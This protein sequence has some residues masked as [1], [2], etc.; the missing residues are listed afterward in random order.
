MLAF[1]ARGGL[2]LLVALTGEGLTACPTTHACVPPAGGRCAGPEPLPAP[3]SPTR[4]GG[5]LTV[6]GV[7][8]TPDGRTLTVMVLCGGTL[9]LHEGAAVSVT[10]VAGAVG[11][12]AMSCALVPL[13]AQL[14]QPLGAR[15]LVDGVSG[16][17]L[18]PVVCH[19]SGQAVFRTACRWS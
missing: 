14:R 15:R 4:P 5:H 19:A 2:A 18:R 10:Y 13:T 8:V 11:A 9:R 16:R 17:A 12:G 3:P 7:A 6:G 1:I